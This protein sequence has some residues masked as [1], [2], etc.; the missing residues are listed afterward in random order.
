M[1]NKVFICFLKILVRFSLR[2]LPLQILCKITF[3]MIW[4]SML[5]NI[6]FKLVL[7]LRRLICMIFHPLIVSCWMNEWMM[8][9]ITC[10]AVY[11]ILI[12]VISI[13]LFLS[14]ELLLALC[15]FISSSHHLIS[16]STFTL[17]CLSLFWTAHAHISIYIHLL[18][19]SALKNT[20]QHCNTFCLFLSLSSITHSHTSFFILLLLSFCISHIYTLSLT[21]VC[22]ISKHIIH[23]H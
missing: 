1:Y 9:F 12:S 4:H 22:N 8:C 5:C 13:L 14:S 20:S 21:S 11:L 16:S 6:L 17:N 10:I 19:F 7:R 18:K 2:V 23:I 3:I 15:I